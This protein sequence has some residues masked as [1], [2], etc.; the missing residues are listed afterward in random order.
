MD[1]IQPL[2]DE[3]AKVDRQ[4]KMRHHPAAINRYYIRYMPVS[5]DLLICSFCNPTQRNN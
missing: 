2:P 1:A 3:A 4:I 5:L